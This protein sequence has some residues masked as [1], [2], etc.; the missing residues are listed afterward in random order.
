MLLLAGLVACAPVPTRTGPAGADAA[1]AARE[2]AFAGR[3]DWAFTGRVALANGDTGGTGRIDWSQHGNDFDVRLAAPVTRQS[4]RLVREHGIVRLEGLEGGT[5]EGP[6]AE[7]LLLEA[8]GWRLPVAAMAEWV[9]G[10]RG[11]G[12]AVVGIDAQGRPASLDQ[13]GWHVEYRD[14][15]ASAPPLPLRMHASQGTASVRVVID[16]WT[17]P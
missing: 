15:D 3:R 8:T 10:L 1:Q 9:R 16:R 14:W 17:A 13:A 7:A 4:W 2:L 6:D 11:P 12:T 5:R